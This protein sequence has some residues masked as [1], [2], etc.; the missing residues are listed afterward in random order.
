MRHHAFTALLAA[1]LAAPAA[2]GAQA[3]L[4]DQ[5]G[6]IT[7]SISFSPYVEVVSHEPSFHNF[8]FY[9]DGQGGVRAGSGA[10]GTFNILSS[11]PPIREVKANTSF[12][13]SIVGLRPDGRLVFTN[14]TGDQLALATA[15]DLLT[16][17]DPSTRNL[18]TIFDCRGSGVYAAPSGSR[19]V[20]FHTYTPSKNDLLGA[21]AGIY[22]ATVY[23]QID[24]A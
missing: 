13:V 6:A 11:N 23:V 24:A 22:T 12:R 20:L 8:T 7:F 2:L 5:S 4:S 10:I 21:A 16:S 19:W 9:A 15:C 18:S 17:S 14:G 1:A 3:Q